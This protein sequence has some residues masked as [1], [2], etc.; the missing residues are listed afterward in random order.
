MIYLDFNLLTGW[1]GKL[2]TDWGYL[3]TGW[4]GKLLTDWGY[5]LTGCVGEL[6]TNWGCST[7]DQLRSTS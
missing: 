6:L 4:V 1:V 7:S 2:L 3:L 5:L